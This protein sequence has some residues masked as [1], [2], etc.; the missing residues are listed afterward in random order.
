MVVGGH[1]EMNNWWSGLTNLFVN[2]LISYLDTSQVV[3]KEIQL[4]VLRFVRL[5]CEN[6]KSMQNRLINVNNP[7]SSIL[8]NNFRNLLRKSSAL[9]IK[10][11]AMLTIWT[12]SGDR[13]I[14]DSIDRKFSLY[15]AIGAQKF[16]DILFD[17]NDELGL[18][19]LE[20]LYCVA[21]GP[22]TRD[23]I[24]NELIKGQEELF[25]YHAIPALLRLLKSNNSSLKFGIL[26]AI[27]AACVTTCYIC[28][29]NNQTAVAKSNGIKL[30][31]DLAQNK[32]TRLRLRVEAYLA[33]SMICFNNSINYDQLCRAYNFNISLLI[34]ELMEFYTIDELKFMKNVQDHYYYSDEY[35]NPV[36]NPFFF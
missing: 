27:S 1:H 13:N 26:K 29:T 31:V 14:Q 22:S 19:C 25:K 11:A 6:D 21:V 16:V 28:N 5:I 10:T 30:L 3:D 32:V 24:T 20:A 17:C 7:S 12:I 2:T 36:I 4:E 23:L 33:L 18:I 34:E 9:S 15:K 35:N 8:I